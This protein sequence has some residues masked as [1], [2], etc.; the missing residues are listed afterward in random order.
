MLSRDKIEDLI[1]LQKKIFIA[2]SGGPD[3]TALV[4]IFADLMNSNKLN[5]E[6]IH[7]NH[8]LSKE[9]KKWEDHCNQV[10]SAL[11]INLITK[12]VKLNSNGGGLESDAR[13]KRYKVFETVLS[14]DSQLLMGH[15]LDDVSETIVLRLLR[16]T[17]ADGLE[18]PPIKRPIGDGVL[19]RPLLEV[20]KKEILKYL[21]NNNIKYIK[22]ES[23]S[24][25][26]FDR[27]LLRNTIFPLIE[28]RWPGFSERIFQTSQIMKDRNYSYKSLLETEYKKLIGSTISIRSLKEIPRSIIKD[29]LRLSIKKSN[30]AVPNKKILDEIIKTFIDSNPGPKSEVSWSRADNAEKS[31]KV[32]FQKGKILISSK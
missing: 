1:D 6:A 7:V 13:N 24:D 22:D 12:S 19:I 11:G 28:S 5:V 27:N 18:G 2:Y 23:N 14:K 4:H 32:T 3:S 8:N 29:I 26:T 31:G 10:C 21:K 15:H 25:N 9:S 16:G 17:G 30:L 20:S